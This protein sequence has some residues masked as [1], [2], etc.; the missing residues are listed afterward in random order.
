MFTARDIRGIEFEEIKKGY[1]KTDVKAFLQNIAN[2][3]EEAERAIAEL[4]AQRDALKLEVTSYE[5][6]M[7]LLAQKVEDF[8]KDED[9]LRTALLSAQRLSVTIIKEARENGEIIVNDAKKKAEDILSGIS[10]KVTTETDAL[11]AIQAE[12]SKF[13]GEVLSIYKTH[14]EILSMLPEHTP[15]PAS[16]PAP[17]ATAEVVETQNIVI[18]DPPQ[19]ETRSFTTTVEIPLVQTQEVP[20]QTQVQEAVSDGPFYTPTPVVDNDPFTSFSS[21]QPEVEVETT[22]IIKEIESE[23]VKPEEILEQPTE[24]RFGQLDFGDGFTFNK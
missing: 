17:E 6:K 1:N 24:S 5:E 21:N 2:Q 20:V 15:E 12:V 18:P 8:R 16:E 22:P 9:S 23:P 3:T 10:D 4:T 14:L 13:K 19:E 7:Q 11:K